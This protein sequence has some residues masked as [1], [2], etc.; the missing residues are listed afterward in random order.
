LFIIRLN[1]SYREEGKRGEEKG[2]EKKVD[3]K[4]GVVLQKKGGG[5]EKN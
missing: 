1:S 3:L 5:G 4:F 2:G